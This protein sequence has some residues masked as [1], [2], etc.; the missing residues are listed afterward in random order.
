MRTYE[1]ID[2][3]REINRMLEIPNLSE[4]LKSKATKVANELLEQLIKEIIK[5]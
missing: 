1:I 4:E 2:A 5:Q 3:F